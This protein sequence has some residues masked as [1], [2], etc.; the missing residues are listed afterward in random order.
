[1]QSYEDLGA[2]VT[3]NMQVS[4]CTQE[5]SKGT[6]PLSQKLSTQLRICKFKALTYWP[7]ECYP[8]SYNIK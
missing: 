8:Y 3:W 6:F 4:H 5:L 7:Y 1:M 2:Y